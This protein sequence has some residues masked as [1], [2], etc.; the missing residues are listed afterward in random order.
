MKYG[1]VYQAVNLAIS[2]AE[3]RRQKRQLF[4]PTHAEVSA[5]VFDAVELQRIQSSWYWD[6]SLLLQYMEVVIW[7]ELALILVHLKAKSGFTA[8][9]YRCDVADLETEGQSRVCTD[10]W[11]IWRR[12]PDLTF[13]HTKYVAEGKDVFSHLSRQFVSKLS[14]APMLSLIFNT[15]EVL[16]VERKILS[17]NRDSG[18]FADLAVHQR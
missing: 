12:L 5:V 4:W 16:N 8:A 3:S 2:R 14:Q 7:V 17:R 11:W 15:P 13:S 9:E 1:A 10:K 18:R 6:A